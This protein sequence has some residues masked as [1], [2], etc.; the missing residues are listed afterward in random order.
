MTIIKNLKLY[1]LLALAACLG[2]IV[3]TNSDKITQQLNIQS[4][5]SNTVSAQELFNAE[6]K[7]E[8]QAVWSKLRTIGITPERFEEERMRRRSQYLRSDVPFNSKPI[9]AQTKQFVQN[10]MKECGLNLNTIT[11][12]GFN[13]GSPAAAT[14]RVIYVNEA[15]FSAL[16]P[17][18]KK[19]VV[20]HEIQHIL[21]GDNSAR[22]TIELMANADTEDMA[23]KYRKPNGHPLLY[24]S[25]FKERRADV[26]TALM[27]PEWAQGYLAFAKERLEKQGNTPGVTHPS[28]SDRFALA[29][30]IVQH[31]KNDRR[32]G[33]V[34]A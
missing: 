15:M 2:Y 26:K 28:H 22:Y 19:F 10:I 25:R 27:G 6:I 1:I 17:A 5:R 3:F 34:A 18:A 8:E 11:I 4:T 24:Y 12:T 33:A 31:M 7:K 9:S 20:G 29:Q 30:R 13:V 23:R 14:E 32:I 21:H 16:S